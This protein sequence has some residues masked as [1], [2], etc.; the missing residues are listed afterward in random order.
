MSLMLTV[1]V[2]TQLLLLYNKVA[3]QLPKTHKVPK[4]KWYNSNTTRNHMRLLK[5]IACMLV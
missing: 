4:S 1:H 5:A 3:I 2:Y